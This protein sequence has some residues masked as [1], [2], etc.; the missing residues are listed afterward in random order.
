MLPDDAL[1]GATSSKP[2]LIQDCM[3]WLLNHSPIQKSWEAE[4]DRTDQRDQFISFIHISPYHE[5]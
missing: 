4:S 1:S 3:F 5:F 2:I